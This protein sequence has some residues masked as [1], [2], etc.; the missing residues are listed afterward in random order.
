MKNINSST[1]S[2]VRKWMLSIFLESKTIPYSNPTS[3]T[4]FSDNFLNF[5]I[6]SINLRITFESLVSTKSKLESIVKK[7]FTSLHSL[8]EICIWATNF[9]VINTLRYGW[10]F[11]ILSSSKLK[12]IKSSKFSDILLF[13]QPK[14]M[15]STLFSLRKEQ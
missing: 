9:F 4:I 1:S 14:F 6:C 7:S 5:K 10:G 15:Y 11:P 12:L 13:L 2:I 8:W 3:S